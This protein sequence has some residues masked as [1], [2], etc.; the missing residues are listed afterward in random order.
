M[1]T[2]RMS[3]EFI[4][5]IQAGAVARVVS[6]GAPMGAKVVGC[7]IERGA[8]SPDV[9]GY[10]TI[11]VEVDDGIEGDRVV[12]FENLEGYEFGPEDVDLLRNGLVYEQAEYAPETVER[13]KSLADRIE[14]RVRRP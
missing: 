7:R 3:P 13:I 6:G 1:S 9:E 11:V 10:H 2:V 5:T 8:S 14:M 12:V 4:A